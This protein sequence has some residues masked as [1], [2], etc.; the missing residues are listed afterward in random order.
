MPEENIWIGMELHTVALSVTQLIVSIPLL[1]RHK[2]LLD[3]NKASQ[4]LIFAFDE[5]QSAPRL[6]QEEIELG[7]RFLIVI[8]PFHLEHLVLH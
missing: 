2:N 8:L 6:C 7:Q 1:P 3:T 5:V 4:L